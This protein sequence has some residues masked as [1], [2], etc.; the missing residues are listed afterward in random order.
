MLNA[1]RLG[2]FIT[3]LH[4]TRDKM[5]ARVDSLHFIMHQI[6]WYSITYML[7]LIIDIY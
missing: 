6:L 2:C 1:L 4:V 5:Q 7:I 3:R